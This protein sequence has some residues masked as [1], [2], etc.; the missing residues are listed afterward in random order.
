MHGY[1]LIDIIRR[2]LEPW[3]I[4]D[5]DAKNEDAKM[6]FRALREAGFDVLMVNI[7]DVDWSESFNPFQIAIDYMQDGDIDSAKD[8]VAKI[9][10]SSSWK[11]IWRAARRSVGPSSSINPA[12]NYFDSALVGART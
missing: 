10:C 12:I 1:I 4:V 7:D 5:T 9:D 2:A 3:N 11:R 6:S 8:E